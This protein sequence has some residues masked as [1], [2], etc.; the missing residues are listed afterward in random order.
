M[1][2]TISNRLIKKKLW[3]ILGFF[4]CIIGL[5]SYAFSS[6]F[7]HLFGEWN[8][9]KIVI[10]TAVSFIISSMMLLMKR[11]KLSRRFLMKAH[12]GVLVLLL[13]SLYSFVSDNKNLNG[14]PDLLSLISCAAFALMSFCLSRHID[15]GFESD[16]LNFF[17][18]IFTLQLMK[19]NL[20]L[21]IVAAIFCYSLMVLRSNWDSCRK[22][23]SSRVENG[24][25][26][27]DVAIEI[28][29]LDNG[30]QQNQS[31]R[32]FDHKDR[33]SWKKYE[34]KSAKGNEN[35]RSYYKCSWPNCMVKKKVERR[36]DGD[37]IETLCKGMHNHRL[38]TTI[39]KRSSSSEYLYALLPSETG[40][41]DLT[42]QS[43]SRDQLDFD[44]EHESFFLSI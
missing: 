23:R 5:I 24:S 19:V 6:S 7:N 22:I 13:T 37:I 34:E 9:F 3:R 36:I 12:L 29:V 44:A 27:R 38:P 4:S 30:S 32:W 43:F 20:M 11:L 14:K 31:L 25:D 42:N 28:D 21:S 39:M 2:I 40:P 10:Y 8:F 41:I 17:L 26:H 15:L 1:P 35:Q 16:L 18:G 33:Y